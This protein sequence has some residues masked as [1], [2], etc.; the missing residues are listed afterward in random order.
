MRFCGVPMTRPALDWTPACDPPP[1][2]DESRGGM[3]S[4]H[5]RHWLFAPPYRCLDP[6]G[7]LGEPYMV[8]GG[9]E[10][11]WNGDR[12]ADSAQLAEV[13]RWNQSTAGGGLW[14]EAQEMAEDARL[15]RARR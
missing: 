14:D 9:C 4:A 5:F 11:A 6:D 8:R 15:G 7:L 12:S 2:R 10:V 1:C 13:A 3:F